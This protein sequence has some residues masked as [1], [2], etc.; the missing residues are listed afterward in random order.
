MKVQS[1]ASIAEESDIRCPFVI[2][3]LLFHRGESYRTSSIIVL[4]FFDYIPR[5]FGS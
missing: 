2:Y 3:F 1:E 4:D 5:E